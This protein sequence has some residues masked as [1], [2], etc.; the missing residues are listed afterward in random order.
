[1][2]LSK[3]QDLPDTSTAGD[4]GKETGQPKEVINDPGKGKVASLKPIYTR[5]PKPTPNLSRA[6]R[7]ETST[8]ELSKTQDLPDTST[9][10]DV[11]KE[12]GQ[13]SVEK[14]AYIKPAQLRRGRLR[15]V[16]NL[17]KWSTKILSPLN[18]KKNEDLNT[19]AADKIPDN[20]DTDL[21]SPAKSHDLGTEEAAPVSEY[22]F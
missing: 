7:K 4:V 8:M 5:F 22:F 18:I 1:M 13:T 16:P 9:A 19:A 12:V 2:E 3:T 6:V 14:P 10:G 20:Q 21:H 15:P 11:C 17:V